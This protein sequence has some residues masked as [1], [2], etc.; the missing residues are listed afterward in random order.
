MRKLY[1]P[2]IDLARAIAVT[3][4]LVYHLIVKWGRQILP[5]SEIF[6][7]FNIGW[8]GVDLFFVISGF[9]ITLSL[10]R[11]INDFGVNDYKNHISRIDWS[12]S[13]H[14]IY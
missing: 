10:C 11:N 5:A 12:G 13:Y 14:C 8:I 3:L 7:I 2:Y 1:F 9:V 6:N 4:V